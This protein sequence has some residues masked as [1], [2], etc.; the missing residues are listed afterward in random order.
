M[1]NRGQILSE[2]G[3]SIKD[4]KKLFSESQFQEVTQAAESILQNQPENGDVHELMGWSLA[5]LERDSEA[6]EHLQKAIRLKS[7]VVANFRAAIKPIVRLGL[8]REDERD[9][10]LGCNS[11]NELAFQDAAE[12]LMRKEPDAAL[13]AI[14]EAGASLF[15]SEVNSAIAAV[16]KALAGVELAT[17][18]TPRRQL[19]DPSPRLAFTCGAGWS[20]STAIFHFLREFEQVVPI[21]G[22]PLVFVGL[23]EVLQSADDVEVMRESLI[24]FFATY[25]IGFRRIDRRMDLKPLEQARR[26]WSLDGA[27][28]GFPGA[29]IDLAR[30][31]S[32][33]IV[34]E[35]SE[36]RA[37]V[38]GKMAK[39]FVNLLCFG[40][41]IGS[42]SVLVFD[43]AVSIANLEKLDIFDRAHALCSFRDPRSNYVAL[44]RESSIFLQTVNPWVSRQKGAQISS[45]EKTTIFDHSDSINV[46]AIQFE[47][48]VLS[49]RFR[50]NLAT[51]LGLDLNRRDKY[52]YFKPWESA[53]NVMLHH[54]HPDQDEIRYIEEHL[55]QFCVEP[56]IAPFL[57]AEGVGEGVP[58]KNPV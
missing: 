19:H 26:R 35:T 45:R 2:D 55:G 12:H 5:Q 13:E 1:E 42:D 39:V 11:R 8:S 27:N 31:V 9:F 37:A 17:E 29:L 7:P 24:R 36:D 23:W 18:E 25:V 3:R 47:E 15:N 32:L 10:W 20:G 4:L 57:D 38:V 43:N 52:R 30:L 16:F 50:D 28:P 56:K 22:E 58:P 34:G 49:E 46:T 44:L 53:R 33:A 48:F 54:E 21:S 40:K 51:G 14:R 6:L 41:A